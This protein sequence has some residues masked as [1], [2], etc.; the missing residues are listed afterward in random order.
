MFGETQM[1]TDDVEVQQGIR[2][3]I[4]LN[5]HKFKLRQLHNEQATYTW[6]RDQLQTS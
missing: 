2:S 3:E 5:R 1:C 4:V 6:W